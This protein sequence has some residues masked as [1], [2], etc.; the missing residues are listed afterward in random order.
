MTRKIMIARV[1]N[2]EA[3]GPFFGGGGVHVWG[4]LAELRPLNFK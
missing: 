3:G 1:R 2:L 4:Q